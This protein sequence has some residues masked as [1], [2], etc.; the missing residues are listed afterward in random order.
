MQNTTC[1]IVLC[2]PDDNMNFCR[3]T[4]R[5]R[6]AISNFPFWKWVRRPTYSLNFVIFNFLGE[7]ER[8]QKENYVT[9]ITAACSFKFIAPL[10]LT[11]CFAPPFLS[12]NSFFRLLRLRCRRN[13][14]D[15]LFSPY[16]TF[17]PICARFSYVET[18]TIDWNHT[19]M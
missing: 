13:T 14:V 6:L 10:D 8:K 15:G 7:N 5:A 1:H 9:K 3:P 17:P 16:S 2:E 11:L 4:K 12:H 18:S 19:A